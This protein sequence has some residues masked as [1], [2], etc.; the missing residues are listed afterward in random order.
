MRVSITVM[1]K[2]FCVLTLF[3]STACGQRGALYLPPH[4]TATSPHSS[5]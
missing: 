2:L 5:S 4:K 3:L 1:L